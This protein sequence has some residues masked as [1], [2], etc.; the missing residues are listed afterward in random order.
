MPKP[1]ITLTDQ[2]GQRF[3]LKP[4]THGKVTLLYFGYT[5]C[6]DV[7][8]LTM[9]MLAQAVKA[10]PAATVRDIAVV[11]VTTDPARDTPAQLRQWLANFDRSFVGLTGSR[12]AIIQAQRQVGAPPSVTEP[13]AKG[14]YGVDHGAFIYA[15]G[16]DDLAHIVYFQGVQPA[17]LAAD[18]R[19]LA[20]GALPAT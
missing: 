18:L 6:P 17:A 12:T 5:H 11:F 20:A 10:L 14:S 15:Y 9:S 8:P 3:A 7:C 1:D 4:R 16:P 2:H 19:R 13:L